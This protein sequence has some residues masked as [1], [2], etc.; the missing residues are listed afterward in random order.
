[1]LRNQPP[2]VVASERERLFDSRV[3]RLTH[4]GV[5]LMGQSARERKELMPGRFDPTVLVQS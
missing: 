1:M 2:Q 4:A 3:V 5:A